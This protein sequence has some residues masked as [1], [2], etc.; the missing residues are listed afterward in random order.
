MLVTADKVGGASYA[1]DEAARLAFTLDYR[2]EK[3]EP[4]P[5]AETLDE[6]SRT[7]TTRDASIVEV[8]PGLRK[9]SDYRT[10]YNTEG[11]AR[12]AAA[13]AGRIPPPRD[14]GPLTVVAWGPQKFLSSELRRPSIFVIFSQPMVPLA[15]LGAASDTSPFVS[16]EP[17]LKGVFRWYGTSFLSFEGDGPCESQQTYTV[18]V[19]PGAESLYGIR[20][21]GE[22]RFSFET[23]RLSMKALEPGAEF[24][25]ESGFR[26]SDEDVPPAAAKKITVIFNYPVKA[27]DIK[28]HI[29]IASDAGGQKDFDL[30]QIDERRV[31]ASL[32]GEVEFATRVTVTLKA[33]ASSGG[34]NLGT[35]TD[36]VLSFRT[37]GPFVVS[38]A[39]RLPPWGKYFNLFDIEF[40]ARLNESTAGGAIRTE[41]D[42]PL[43]EDHVEVEGSRVRIFNLPLGF[44]EKFKIIA[45]TGIEDVYGRHLEKRYET[46]ITMPPE[47]LPVGSAVFLDWGDS[48]LEAQFEPRLLFEYRNIAEKSFY[49]LEQK[50]NPWSPSSVKTDTVYLERFDKNFRYLEE[51]DLRPYLNPGYRGFVSFN[52]DLNLLR[53]GVDPATGKQKAV[54]EKNTLRLQVTDLGLTVRHAFN[55]T[56][57]MVSS[58]S[59]GEPVE[60]AVVRLVAPGVIKDTEDISGAE[61]FAEALTGKDGLAVLGTR[62]GALRN[63]KMTEDFWRRTPFVFAEKDGDRAVFQPYSHHA[64][65]FGVNAVEPVTAEAVRPVTFLFSDR[66]LYKPGETLTFRGVDRSLVLGIYAIYSGEYTVE[67]VKGGWRG[68]AVASVD[69]VT[70]ES[71][72]CYGRIRLGEELTPGQYRLRYKRKDGEVCA[73]IPVTIA[74]FER[75]RFQA[76]VSAPAL[77]VVSGDEINL[78]L[79]ASYLSGGNLGGAKWYASWFRRLDGF[80]PDTAETKAFVFGPRNVYDGKRAVSSSAGVLSADGKAVLTQ[81]TSTDSVPGA[82]YTYSVEATVTD[83]SNQ[84]IS[85]SRTVTVHP[86]LFYIGI[87]RPAAHGFAKAGEEL[88]FNYITVNTSGK[89]LTDDSRFLSNGGEAGLI[90]VELIREEWTR[91]QQRGVNN[92]V[93]DNY[94]RTEVIDGAKKLELKVSG[95]V[96]VKPSK[97][98][99]YILRLYG[100]D[101]EGRK[102]LTEYTFYVT[103]TN[104]SYWN[105]NDSNEINLV[106][107]RAVYNP[108]DT[109]EVLLQSPLPAGRYLITVEREGIFT[110]EVRVFDEAVSVISVP[111]AR[112]FTPVVYLSVSSYSTRR[113]PP[114]HEYGTPDLD[115]PKGYYGVAKLFV[116]P[117]SR[118]FSVKVDG[119]KKV[120]RPGEE[121]TLT[122]TAERDGVPLPG[123][124]LSLMAVDRGVLDLTGYRVPDPVSY[125]YNETYFPLGVSGGDSRAL[126][127][128]PVT[129]SVKNLYGGDSGGNKIEERADF[130]PTAVFDPFLLT[131]ENGKV[132]CTFTL[133]DTLTTYRITVFGVRGDLFSLKETEIAA[134]NVV[135]VQQVQPRRLRE[136]DTAEAGVLITN[137]DSTPHKVSVSIGIEEPSAGY[138]GGLL[139]QAGAAFVD[140]QAE[141]TVT[142]KAG[143]NALV[144]FDVAAEKQGEVNLVY[145]VKSDVLDERLVQGIVIEKP[146]ITE[147]VVTMGTLADGDRDKTE[148][149]VIPAFAD[150][151]E[152]SLAVTLDAAR[153]SLL[154]SA[155][156]YL[157]HYPYGCMEQ[158]SAAVLPLVIFGEYIDALNLAGEV[159][160]PRKAAQKEIAAWAKTQR[161]DGG[162]PY[163]PSGLASDPYVSLRIAHTLALAEEKSI[164]LPS[165]LSKD[166]LYAYLYDEYQK[167][168]R[169]NNRRGSEAEAV[170]TDPAY[171]RNVYLQAY[172]LYVFSLLKKPVDA[173]RVSALAAANRDN[174]AVLA[175]AG[176]TAQA[177]SRG[178]TAFDLARTLR[179]LLRPSARGVDLSGGGGVDPGTY[180]GGRTE[181]LALTLQFFA[182]QYP[183]DAINTR[184]LNTLLSNKRADGCWDNTAVTVRVLAA[185]ARLIQTE[186]LDKTNVTGAVTLDGRT[187]A[188]ASFNGPGTKALTKTFPFR[189]FPLAA[190]PRDTTLPFKISRRGT[191]SLYW[192]AAL[193]YALPAEMQGRRDEGIGVFQ[194]VYDYESGEPVK[195]N[196]LESGK[197]YRAEVRVS[198][199]RDRTFVALRVPV[200][201]GTEILNSAFVT[202]SSAVQD[203][204]GEDETPPAYYRARAVSS[205]AVFDNEIQYFWD[206]FET[207]E[208]TVRFL[209]RAARR[210]VYPVPPA[211]AECM[212][213]SEIFG[214]SEG[215]LC[216]IR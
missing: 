81:K 93:Y 149:L 124:E 57:V 69:G 66:G 145:T 20:I 3:S 216:T 215:A 85:A 90:S 184:L 164:P 119:G 28:S 113:G 135:N 26:F 213:E 72:G 116:N 192:T 8:I 168:Y 197:L 42:M 35:E 52:A 194:T 48:M 196:Q 63:M 105:R 111:V 159:S 123:A 46:E 19:S 150:D 43:T 169:E 112:N 120:F 188:G 151:G 155:A 118:A 11:P 102:A 203:T 45:G 147:T 178:D 29:V 78:T 202:T 64:W 76:S 96:K 74:Y 134:R 77:D 206:S 190:L 95:S 130:N 161:P 7:A 13:A 44:G 179:N 173:S 32:P 100:F 176:M 16:I 94:E 40:S 132:K 24:R 110:E 195:E 156:G 127:I 82:A 39:A 152:G 75:L 92:Y 172:M 25:K 214:R 125:F 50:N 126:L 140:G 187:L 142:V 158:R 61:C 205:Q 62:A 122:L 88:S 67:L 84:Q 79:E 129:Y 60:G 170:Q 51:I 153:L 131:D 139:K 166:K 83:V 41:P 165:A 212:Y 99:F 56:V 136:R 2:S 180:Y 211:Q 6:A 115:K 210:G 65:R 4:E 193:S 55:K 128:D 117:R 34:G 86:T 208:T 104:F 154:E 36:Q 144:Y 15:A 207:G 97:S 175:F 47:P 160:N 186:N 18:A 191:G 98:G 146:Y 209:F 133:P 10:A 181:Q 143:G 200:P 37:P 198:S 174:P 89:K 58:L 163:W 14:A 189:D 23:E 103:G 30:T 201:S 1:N 22:T 27:A 17:P 171:M 38:E 138:D 108:G 54:S 199:S 59:T 101:R 141:R 137:L 49:T 68:E 157:F 12:P 21:E 185:V 70:S 148:A 106:P 9:L 204:A 91:V 31:L 53:R 183:G 162:F 71:G 73:D 107:D 114:V 167:L 182:G 80:Y 177:M 33:G 109:A 121:V 87:E 5:E